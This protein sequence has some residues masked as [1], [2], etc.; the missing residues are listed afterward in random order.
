[1]KNPLG[2]PAI[3]LIGA[4]VLASS[5]VIAGIAQSQGGQ[6][7]SDSE[8]AAAYATIRADGVSRHKAFV[9]DFVAKGRDPRSLEQVPLDVAYGSDVPLPTLEKAIGESAAIVHG[10]VTGCATSSIRRAS[11]LR[12]SRSMSRSRSKGS[13]VLGLRS[14]RLEG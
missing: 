13:L 3:V 12:F 4:G 2:R 11:C 7:E 8:R 1:M 14:S 5:V 10:V 9:A 6:G